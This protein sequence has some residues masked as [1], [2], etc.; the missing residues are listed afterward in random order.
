MQPVLSEVRDSEDQG[1]RERLLAAEE[2]LR[3]I[4]A[5]EVD[6]VVVGPADGKRIF[7]LGGVDE[8]YR[9]FVESMRQGAVTVAREGT[10]LYA[11][12]YFAE[13]VDV[14]V[15]KV[16]GS[17]IFE[18]AMP[19]NEAVL[20]AL[21]WG[22]CTTAE[23]QRKFSF[24]SSTGRQLPAEL[25]GTPLPVDG[26]IHVCLLV[27]DL[28]DR[29]ARLAAEV[30]NSAKDRFLALLSHELR[31]PLMPAMLLV[32]EMEEDRRL[33]TDTRES[34]GI[35]RRSLE[36]QTRLIDDLLDLS[37]VVSGRLS[38]Q[39]KPVDL[40]GVLENAKSTVASEAQEKRLRKEMNLGAPTGAVVGDEARLQQV[41]WNL[42]K[43]AV[44]FSTPDGRIV[45]RSS[46]EEGLVIVTVQDEGE[47]IDPKVL[48]RIF[49]A[50]E[51]GHGR[52]DRGGL[53]LGLAIAKGLVEAHGGTISAQSGGA[54]MGT[55][56]RVGLPLGDRRA[57]GTK[58][59]AGRGER[60]CGAICRGGGRIG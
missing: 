19:E 59:D 21:V 43:N 18:F 1:L 53:G 50:F 10:I 46:V 47:G 37:R 25:T 36:M 42:L 22:A 6:A 54:G 40:D 30:A 35:V 24:R 16:I 31:T 44:K 39:T 15:E 32:S 11:N 41:F 57:A 5:H 55:C 60:G 12:R 49:N 27:T 26:H 3:A 58:G 13:M 38:L 33:S 2:V 51:Q 17:S 28:R 23:T 7:T 34:L 9:T 48:P 56:V 45:V 20:R 29:E 52:G 14:P 4:R 8:G